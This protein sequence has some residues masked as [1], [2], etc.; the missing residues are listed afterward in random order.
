MPDDFGNRTTDELIGDQ[1]ALS[2][3]AAVETGIEATMWALEP[4]ARKVFSDITKDLTT[5]NLGSEDVKSLRRYLDL[6]FLYRE[7]GDI[8]DANFFIR[9]VVSV[10]STSV[11][12]NGFGMKQLNTSTKEIAFRGSPQKPGG[13]QPGRKFLGMIP[14]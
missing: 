3:A 10:C 1:E 4:E 8:E 9:K 2:T 6:A 11:S 13:Q 14:Y 12:I 7:L 5:A